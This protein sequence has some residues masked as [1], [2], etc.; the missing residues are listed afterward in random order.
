MPRTTGSAAVT[1]PPRWHAATPP[2]LMLLAWLLVTLA[3]TTSRATSAEEPTTGR[4]ITAGTPL[5]TA[6]E[7]LRRQGLPLVYSTSLVGPEL[8][9]VA[10]PASSTPR[11]VL[12]EILAPL[13]LEAIAAGR[14]LVVVRQQPST[15]AVHGRV[16]ARGGPPLAGVAVTLRD[17][18]GA[19]RVV[20]DERGE[21]RLGGLAAGPVEVELSSPGFVP[22]RTRVQVTAGGEAELTLELQPL[23]VAREEIT[24]TP[25]RY[26]LLGGETGGALLLDRREIERLPHLADDVYRALAFLPGTSG[27]DI[28]ARLHVRGG[29]EDEVLVLLD[30]QEVDHPFHLEDFQSIFSIVDTAAIGSLDFLTG[31][32]PAR[33]GTRLSG[34]VDISTAVPQPG[35]H[36]ALGVSFLHARAFSAGTFAGDRGSWLASARRGYLDF[37]LGLVRRRGDDFVLSP[38]YS[39]LLARAQVHWGDR[40]TLA[41]D[42]LASY[43]AVRFAN[44]GSDLDEARARF[45]NAYAWGTATTQWTPRLASTTLVSLG[46]VESHRRVAS[47]DLHGIT[48]CDLCSLRTAEVDDRRAFAALT[49][50]QEWTLEVSPHHRLAAGLEARRLAADYRYGSHTLTLDPLLTGSP[51]VVSTVHVE[52]LRPAGEQYA[53]YLSDRALLGDAFVAELGL[54]WDG[55][56]WSHDSVWSPRLELLYRLGPRHALRAAWGRYSQGQRLDE[57]QVEDGVT[58]FAP[59]ELAEQRLVGWEASPRASVHLRVEAYD[60][61]T[62]QLR[63][64]FENLFEPIDLAP[65]AATD[66]VRVAPSGSQARGVEAMLEWE[67]GEVWNLWSSYTLAS[68][69]DRIDGAWVARAWEER[70][71]ARL[72][73]ERRLGATWSLGVAATYHS[74]WPFTPVTATLV[75]QNG[76]TTVVPALG[77]RNGARYS[78]YQRLDA[79]ASREVAMRHGTL[80]LFLEVTNVLDRHNVR[81]ISSF[82]FVVA[83]DSVRVIPQTEAWLPRIPS[84]GFTW[85]F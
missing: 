16:Q 57:L 26:S 1:G 36:T 77:P 5:V 35:R 66:R 21:L 17:G 45:G 47:D 75:R 9:V 22:L 64:R 24:V 38:T 23:P 51:L 30:G 4:P 74:G 46:H 59:A 79:R 49:V 37:V 44:H 65:E 42:V 2:G 39:D 11:Q 72:G 55:Q 69:R 67:P 52:R 12:D 81:A 84:F 78:S 56:S 15:G 61:T 40:T 54:R 85:S 60:K 48:S 32:F 34:V 53:G 13:H 28:S 19:H 31:G 58:T 71:A 63:P 20:S 68:A 18:G 82:D 14:E 8:R 73:V 10:A 80:T 33:Y 70:H 7:T 29:E 76:Q 43:D 25:S 50:K 83:G 62:R 3:A 6:L 27:G 41:G